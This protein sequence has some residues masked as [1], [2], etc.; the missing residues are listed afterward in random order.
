MLIDKLSFSVAAPD[1][2]N[3]DSVESDKDALEIPKSNHH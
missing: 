1:Q 2:N 3:T